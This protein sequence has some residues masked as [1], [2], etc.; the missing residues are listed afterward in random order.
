MASTNKS[1]PRKQENLFVV[2]D[3]LDL[4]GFFPEQVPEMVEEFINNAFSLKL[5]R[6]KIIHGKGKSRLKYEVLK[7]LESNP[8]VAEFG[9]APPESGG[10]GAT[11]IVLK[12]D[13]NSV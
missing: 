1:N 8:R 7:A 12:E 11:I 3:L 5:H 13:P 10:W 4:H 2:T 6:L 9:D